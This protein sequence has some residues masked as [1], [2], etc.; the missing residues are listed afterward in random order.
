MNFAQADPLSA[1]D[2]ETLLENLEKIQNSSDSKI[3]ERFRLAISAYRT[4]MASD[5]AAMSLYLNCIEKVNFE[6]QAKKAADFREWKRKEADKMSDTGFRLALRYQLRW[7]VL[8][9]QAASP[10]ADRSKLL[11]EAQD[12]VDSLF[13]D[14][15]KLKGQ[16]QTLGQGVT[17]TVFAKAYDINQ[18]KVEDWPLSPL[19]LDQIY[20]SILFPPNR[21]PSRVAALRASWIK[22]I[23]QETIKHEAF[24]GRQRDD[25]RVGTV[26]SMQ[27]PEFTKFL[28]EGVPR[29]QWQMEMDLFKAGDE[30]G[31]AVRMLD[32][33]KKYVNHPNAREWGDQF[34]SLLKPKV[35]GGPATA[36]SGN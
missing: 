9:L 18:A 3:D 26:E 32:H 1:A 15:V 12:A 34:K 5:D 16:Q 33:L 10:N 2:R 36:A 29:M 11:G 25:K 24:G 35:V 30:N 31:A 19:D 6:D 21:T 23:Q 17:S 20:G 4:A 7:L 13:R 8:T 28:Q 22:R 27:S 14:I